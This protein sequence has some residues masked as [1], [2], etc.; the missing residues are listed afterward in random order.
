MILA[1]MIVILHE[2]VNLSKYLNENK[3]E[4]IAQI[5]LEKDKKSISKICFIILESFSLLSEIK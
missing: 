1:N 2:N 3:Y 5:K 4:F